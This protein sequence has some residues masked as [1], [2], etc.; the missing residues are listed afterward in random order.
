MAQVELQ[1]IRKSYGA[2]EIIQGAR[3]SI[4]DGEFVV[5]VG[6]SGCGKSTLLRCIAGLETITSGKLMI[7][8][9]DMTAADPVK[10][11]ISMVFQSYALYPHM[12]VAENI[13]FGLKIG[14]APKSDAHKRVVE[15]ARLLKLDQLLARKPK[16]L[17][18]GQR[19]R[20]AI[21]RA[22]ARNP[23]IF[24]FDEPLS[25]LDASLR[26]EM[27][28]ELAK[29]HAA[30][31]NTMIYVTHDQVEA[32]TLADRI[33]V[34]RAGVIEQVGSPLELFNQPANKFVAGFLGQPP[35]NFIRLEEVRE[36]GGKIE[37]GLP[38]G[39]RLALDMP[40][41]AKGATAVELG[42][43]P[44]DMSIDPDGPLEAVIDVVEQLG[45]E[46]LLYCRLAD[47]QALV[48]KL[49]GQSSHKSGDRLR[50]GMS[51]ERLH[52]F[53]ADGLNLR[54]GGRP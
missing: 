24:L 29:L 20:V 28:V 23:R 10:R 25:N 37:A 8:G 19:Q 47:E 5:L 48:A 15:V 42:V 33:V 46:T 30:L 53:D 31:G 7:D 4:G 36:V 9:A 43:R 3:L 44:E 11:G 6:P 22:L 1:D 26:A 49:T 40:A 52:L 45:G 41:S 35:M 18:G 32:M 16:E 2:I 14:G 39:G 34:M 54:H 17:S 38:G 51:D 13:G 21:G 50:F 27:R 12:T